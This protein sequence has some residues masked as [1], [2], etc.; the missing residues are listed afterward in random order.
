MIRE[1]FNGLFL[2]LVLV[3]PICLIIGLI[4]PSVFNKIFRKNLD[5]KATSLIFG[6]ALIVFFILFGVTT[7]PTSQK[8]ASNQITAPATVATQNTT[9]TKIISSNTPVAS[10]SKPVSTPAQTPISTANPVCNPNWQCTAWNAC[11]NSTQTRTCND[12]NNCNTANG[13]PTLSQSC[14]MPTPVSTETV[15]QQNAVAKAK[16]YLNYSAFSRD[17][18]VDQLVYDQ[19]SNADAVYGVDNSGADWNAQAAA[20]AKEYMSYSAFSRGGLITQLEYDKFT[21]AQ[22]EYGANSVGL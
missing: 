8:V 20:K 3:A 14:T 11:S 12:S 10:S 21:E 15:S 22:A 4:K 13:K 9:A 16:E 19:F 18:L 17:G 5:R 2:I 6:V 7:P 1:F